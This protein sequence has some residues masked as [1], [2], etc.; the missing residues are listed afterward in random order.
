MKPND[1]AR[2]VPWLGIIRLTLPLCAAGLVAQDAGPVAERFADCAVRAR[3]EDAPPPCLAGVAKALTPFVLPSSKEFFPEERTRFEKAFTRALHRD[4]RGLDPNLAPEAVSRN[5]RLLDVVW[6][7]TSV[8]RRYRR[9][10]RRLVKAYSFAY[11]VGEL[12][13]A[14][15]VVLEDFESQ[16]AGGLPRG[17]KW[18]AFG[19]GEEKPYRVVSE[20]G[21]QFLRAEDH[22]ENVMLYKE[23]RW[24]ARKY[25]YLAWRWRIRAVPEGADAREEARADSAAG[26]YL[27]Y[28]R[29]LGLVP[30]SV[31]F[32]W[33]G[34]L[35]PG[36]AFRRPGIGMPWTVV[37]GSGEADGE[38]WHRVVVH[39][40]D[41]Y[42]RTFGGSGAERPLGI[43]VLSDANNTGSFA[44]ADYDDFVALAAA[45]EGERLAVEEREPPD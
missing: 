23:V 7:E 26:V 37:A 17:W 41:V 14:G 30:V 11:L 34:H 5:G 16:P 18:R 35:S 22:G 9:L 12:E 27:T 10:C 42:R 20:N 3:S 2:G 38:R 24:D 44:A 1:R 8:R 28:R 45:D 36:T 43:G 33:S 19:R 4:L 40:G 31:K 15:A 25:P 29:K 13:D 39:V 32:I 6:G 21:N